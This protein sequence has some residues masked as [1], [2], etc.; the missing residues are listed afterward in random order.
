MA[1]VISEIAEVWPDTKMVHGR[2][3]H[4]Q[5]QGGI[6]RLNRTCQEKLGKWMTTNKSKK[7]T[8][9]RL[10]VRWQINT[11]LH[12]TVGS[13]PYSLAFGMNPRLGL[14]SLPVSKE[15]LDKLQT[16]A[17]VPFLELRFHYA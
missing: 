16:E 11:Q 7:W 15:L 9:G 13:M 5:S 10:F 14:S 8:V 12:S 2:A 1:E 6:E 4:S 17:Q 3:R